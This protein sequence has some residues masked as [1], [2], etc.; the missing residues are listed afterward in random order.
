MNAEEE[1]LDARA[2]YYSLNSF[3]SHTGHCSSKNNG[4]LS[5]CI[6]VTKARLSTGRPSVCDSLWDKI[7]LCNVNVAVRITSSGC[8][9]LHAHFSLHIN[10]L[11]MHPLSFFSLFPVRLLWYCTHCAQWFLNLMDCFNIKSGAWQCCSLIVKIV[12]KT[13]LW[14]F[15]HCLELIKQRISF[16]EKVLWH[17]SEELILKSWWW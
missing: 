14:G 2:I 10:E 9:C 3:C 11:C 16:P 5:D 7:V 4:A 13:E 17:F 8:L 6:W 15:I 1:R 12:C